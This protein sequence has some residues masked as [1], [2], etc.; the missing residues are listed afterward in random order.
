MPIISKYDVA[1]QERLMDEI[2]EILAKDEAPRDLA[3]M[4]LGNVTTHILNAH[5]PAEKRE[6]VARQ[7][8]QILLQSVT[9]QDS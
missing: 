4:T 1:R 5:V 2:L 6:A 3:L 7:F 9:H 8:G